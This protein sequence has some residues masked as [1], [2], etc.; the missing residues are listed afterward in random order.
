MEYNKKNSAEDI[1]DERAANAFSAGLRCSDLMEELGRARPKTMSELMESKQIRSGED[2]YNNKMA[3]S[4]G[5]NKSSRQRNQR[6]RSRNEDGRTRRNQV[7]AGY[8]R[9]DEEGDENR[10]YQD[11]GNRRR[12]KLIYSDPSA[13][14]M[15]HGP[16]RI[17][18]A[19]LDGKRGFQSPDERLHDVP[20]TARQH[21]IEP[22]S[23]SRKHDAG[24][25][26][27]RSRISSTK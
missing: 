6:R 13:E 7:A 9:G 3:R 8:E 27:H 5:G 20:K 4:L 11:K 22:R 15:L 17:H 24:Q 10:E 1:S 21:E 16:C 19:Y 12:E 18:Y 23:A 14:D 26:N 2:A 25:R